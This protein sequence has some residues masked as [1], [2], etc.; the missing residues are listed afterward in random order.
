MPKAAVRLRRMP[1]LKKF[2]YARQF[3]S[4]ARRKPCL[5]RDFDEATHER[6][7]QSTEGGVY[8]HE[9]CGQPQSGVPATTLS[10]HGIAPLREKIREY[11]I[12]LS[13]YP[14]LES[15]TA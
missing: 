6:A 8:P 9:T 13:V 5:Q 7:A 3:V 15:F 2:P 10:N 14:S 1:E 4:G 12:L 11:Y